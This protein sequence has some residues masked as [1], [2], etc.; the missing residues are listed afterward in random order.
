MKPGVHTPGDSKTGRRQVQRPNEPSAIL[1]D[2]GRALAHR[3][4]HLASDAAGSAHR[5]KR[6]AHLL[7]EQCRLLEGGEVAAAVKLLEEP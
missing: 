5:S 2:G 4:P 6:A 3:V 1:R 7:D